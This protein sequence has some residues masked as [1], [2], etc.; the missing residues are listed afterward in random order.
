MGLDYTAIIFQKENGEW[1]NIY[2]RPINIFKNLPTEL[3][4]ANHT[5]PKSLMEIAGRYTEW[6][7][8]GLFEK[9]NTY[10]NLDLV[11]MKSVANPQDY[12]SSCYCISGAPFTPQIYSR[13]AFSNLK[14]D[15]RQFEVELLNDQDL[16]NIETLQKE[17]PRKKYISLTD[18]M[19]NKLAESGKYFNLY[20][21][22]EN[23]H[24]GNFY[25][26]DSFNSLK[27]KFEK[28]YESK[29]KEFNKIDELK[30]SIEY[31]K[32]SSDEKSN[33]LEEYEFKKE[34]LTEV[35]DVID[36]C[37]YFENVLDYLSE[38]ET[39]NTIEDREVIIFIYGEW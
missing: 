3:S 39:E 22:V 24:Q 20:A 10:L 1:K 9:E 14:L 2:T 8:V 26:I 21:K 7:Y 16:K 29:L 6:E 27:Q 12:N 15:L 33:F 4:T 18:F 36:T 35:K 31:M 17:N 19:Q 37:M 13:E 11:P 38:F 5:V 34:C 32:L 30:S 28:K 25:N 23:F